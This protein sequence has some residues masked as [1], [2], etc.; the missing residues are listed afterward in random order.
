MKFCLQA[1]HEFLWS[2][3]QSPPV[4]G[5]SIVLA[6][7]FFRV[8][9]LRYLNCTFS[10][11]KSPAVSSTSH[12][13]SRS[14]PASLVP[15]QLVCFAFAS[16][17]SIVYFSPPSSWFLLFLSLFSFF[18]GFLCSFAHLLIYGCPLLL[19]TL[20][21]SFPGWPHCKH[22]NNHKPYWCNLNVGNMTI[23]VTSLLTLLLVGK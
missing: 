18:A 3:Y 5:T 1:F 2:V 9:I 7:Y 4:W 23:W 10:A 14:H 21:I 16:L 20:S 15:T 6:I 8:E 22:D 12:P 11:L 19:F 13:D 17:L